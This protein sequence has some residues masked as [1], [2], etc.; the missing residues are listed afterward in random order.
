MFFKKIVLLLSIL[1]LKESSAGLTE[2]DCS[3]VDIREKNP[4]ISQ[5]LSIP[6][7]Q[8]PFSWCYSFATADLLSVELG[9]PV[10]AF[11]VATIYNK[12]VANNFIP[13]LRLKIN[14]IIN[15]INETEENSG[16]EE[17]INEGYVD[18]AIQAVSN[19]EYVCSE[20]EVSLNSENN[21][22]IYSFILNLEKIKK[23]FIDNPEIMCEH[24]KESLVGTLFAKIDFVKITQS[25]LKNQ[26]NQELESMIS[27][28]C[29]NT[30][31]LTKKF[32]VV[33]LEKPVTLVGQSETSLNQQNKKYFDVIGEVLQSGKPLAI[34][35]DE[36]WV[37]PDTHSTHVNVITGRRWQNNKCEFKFRNSWGKGCFA[38][39]EFEC[40]EDEGS[41][42]VNDETFLKM[43]NGIIY[44]EK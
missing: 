42:W 40:V 13:S 6:R 15:K 36:K 4:A 24:V 34:R 2:E 28:S 23:D 3:A 37:F 38:S 1:I 25:L 44:I 19:E 41:F 10:S 20:S 30:K 17:V 21:K 31:M 7:N 8:G 35:Y 26:L 18:K 29:N 11:H 43:V 33:Q 5:F 9:Q 39:K 32:N 27:S 22:K 16:F 14:K 12:S